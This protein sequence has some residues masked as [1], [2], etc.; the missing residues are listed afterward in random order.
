[1]G[2]QSEYGLNCTAPSE[3]SAATPDSE[4]AVSKVAATAVTQYYGKKLGLSAWAFRLYSIYGPYEDASRL[5]IRLLACAQQK[6]LPPLVNPSISR[7]FIHVDDVCRAVE[8]VISQADRLPKGEVYNIGTGHCTTLDQLVSI[9]T[10]TFGITDAPAWGSMAN[11][12]WDHADWYSNP[13]KAKRELGWQATLTLREGL[14]KTM[15][16]IKQH[17]EAMLSATQQ[18]VA[19]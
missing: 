2:S 13:A 15:N 5:I 6:K 16:W 9:A 1:M 19:R 14:E 11:R 7:D 10:E 8:A 12:H 4:Y 18:S 3:S 17:P